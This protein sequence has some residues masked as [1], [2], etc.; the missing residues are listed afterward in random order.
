MNWT[1]SEMKR[2]I[3]QKAVKVNGKIITS[4]K[5]YPFKSGDILEIGK[6]YVFRIV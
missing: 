4:N 2:L 3:K 6:K 5:K 1:I